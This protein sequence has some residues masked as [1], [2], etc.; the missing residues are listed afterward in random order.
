MNLF[1]LFG[2]FSQLT[3]AVEV[4]N[5]QARDVCMQATNIQQLIALTNYF[6]DCIG[7]CK[8]TTFVRY[9]QLTNLFEYNNKAGNEA[10]LFYAN[11]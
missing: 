8:I 1:P 4:E 6:R 11:T 5:I 2:L 7:N 10:I 9:G 3:R